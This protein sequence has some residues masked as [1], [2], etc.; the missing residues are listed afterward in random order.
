[1]TTIDVWMTTI[2]RELATERRF[3]IV[4]IAFGLGI[5]ALVWAV[6]GRL[7]WGGL[8]GGTIAIAVSICRIRYER[9]LTK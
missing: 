9:T 8:V 4:Y 5:P 7:G 3:Q 6:T 1:M 2:G